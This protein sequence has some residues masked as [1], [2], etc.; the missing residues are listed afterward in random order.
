[1]DTCD[2]WR[3]YLGRPVDEQEAQAL[4]ARLVA[5]FQLLRAWDESDA[6]ELVRNSAIIKVNGALGSS[7][8]VD[9]NCEVIVRR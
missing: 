9:V 8:A 7:P 4:N 2:L 5:Y 6:R 1:M 3:R